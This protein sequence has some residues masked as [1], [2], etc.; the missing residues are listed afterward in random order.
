MKFKP[1][2]YKYDFKDEALIEN[3]PN[4]LQK[5]ITH[6]LRDLFQK[7]NLGYNRYNHLNSSITNLNSSF[8]DRTQTLLREVFNSDFG[9]FVDKLFSDT[10]LTTN[11]LALMLQNYARGLDAVRLEMILSDG[12]SAYKVEKTDKEASESKEGVYDLVWRVP[13]AVTQQSE[14]ALTNNQ[15]LLEAWKQCYS[16][17]P[18]YEKTVSKCC[19]FLEGY[20]GK[21]YFPEDPKPQLG[22][23][24]N[25]F[26]NNPKQ[27]SYKGDSIVDPKS[28]L[29]SLLKEAS[30]IR[31]QHTEG[32][33]REPTS[34]EAE[35]ILHTTI[36]I[37]NLHDKGSK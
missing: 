2:S 14:K 27:L 1:F 35:F 29:T 21:T 16:R 8:V 25:N 13:E 26:E 28:I 15:L 11:F 19:D 5:P 23:F 32:Q 9:E 34:D 3:Y 33:G 22:K 18:D 7:N 17:H 6:W 12:G 30:N 37:W 20:L 24:I 4:Y 31:G 36:Y 10:E